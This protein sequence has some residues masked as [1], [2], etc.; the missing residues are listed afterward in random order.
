MMKTLAKVF[1]IIGIIS[2]FPTVVAPIV[3]FI[4][5]SKMNKGEKS[6]GLAVC[7]IIFCSLLGGIFQL[8]D[9]E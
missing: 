9:K 3:G 5:L 1:T 6:V 7:N 2:L 8:L 4:C